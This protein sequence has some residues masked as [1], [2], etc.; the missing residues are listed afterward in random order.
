MEIVFDSESISDDYF[1]QIVRLSSSLSEE[2]LV[3]KAKVR[4]EEFRALPG[5]VQKY[6][7]KLANEGN[8]AGIYIWDSKAS[9]L[10]YKASDLAKTIGEAYEV[11]APPSVEL[12]DMLFL[13]RE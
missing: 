1:V 12:G 2:E 7:V 9:F 13:L 8:Y 4:A 10:E 5:L 11:T 6:Y 3:A